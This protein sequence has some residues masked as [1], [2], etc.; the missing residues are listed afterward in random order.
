MNHEEIKKIIED[1]LKKIP[2]EFSDIKILNGEVGGCKKFIIEGADTGL[3]IGKDGENLSAL[4]HVVKR[5]VLKNETE[6]EVERFYIDVGDYHTKKIQKIKNLSVTMANRAKT[7]K[8]NVELEPM[9]A[10]ERM[11]V[12]ATLADDG[13]IKTESEGDGKFR[14]VVIKFVG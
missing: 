10:Y 2:L 12:H 3:L 5:I 8:R 11:V 14:R 4:N 1:I 6:G 7:F 13:L 9:S